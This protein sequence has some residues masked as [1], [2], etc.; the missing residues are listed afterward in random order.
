MH[1]FASLECIWLFITFV[2]FSLD[3]LIYLFC[4]FASN[5]RTTYLKG[6]GDFSFRV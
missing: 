4:L 6:L 5:N 1:A 2:C 3:L